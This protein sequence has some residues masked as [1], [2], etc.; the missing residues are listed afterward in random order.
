MSRIKR[1]FR[2]ALYLAYIIFNIIIYFIMLNEGENQ[3]YAVLNLIE[4]S[5]LFS[6]YFIGLI[7]SLYIFDIINYTEKGEKKG[8]AGITILAFI[9]MKFYS[10]IFIRV[11]DENLL[12]L[13]L[14]R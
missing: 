3:V 12:I 10:Y 6:I 2:S 9:A 4:N 11:I 5:M 7:S 13:L 8:G 1:I 14:T